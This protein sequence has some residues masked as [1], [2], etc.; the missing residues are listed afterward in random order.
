M[1]KAIIYAT[2]GGTC[3]IMAQKLAEKLK[4]ADVFD[5]KQ[6]PDIKDYDIIIFGGAY[7]A[8]MLNRKLTKFVKKNSDI[9]KEKKYA[10]FISCIANENYLDVLK[11]NIGEDIMKSSYITRWFGYGASIEEAKG[12]NKL[13]TKIMVA[14]LKK[15]NKPTTLINDEEIQGF[16]D[17]I[18]D[19]K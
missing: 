16:A 14:S 18:N 10:F 11:T 3:R 17:T 15:Q 13:I 5:V 2:K 6:A 4:D 8:S 12:L 7:Y 19:I 9:L 1:K